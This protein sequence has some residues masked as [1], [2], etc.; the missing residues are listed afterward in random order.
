[1]P[2]SDEDTQGYWASSEIR[3]DVCGAFNKTSMKKC[4][5]CGSELAERQVSINKE[6]VQPPPEPPRKKS[7][8]PM[9]AIVCAAV[10]LG[11]FAL[12][13]LASAVGLNFFKR[14]EKQASAELFSTE[15]SQRAASESTEQPSAWLLAEDPTDPPYYPQT[16]ADEAATPEAEESPPE[17]TEPAPAPPP[18]PPADWGE[19]FIIADS[20]TRELDKKDVLGLTPQ[21]L[22]IARNEIYAKRGRMFLDPLL[23][24]YFDSK[25]WYQSLTV[26]YAPSV[27][28]SSIALTPVELKNAELLLNM[29]KAFVTAKGDVFPDSLERELELKDV[30]LSKD[31]LKLGMEQLYQKSGATIY[32]AKSQLSDI[33]R[34]NADLIEWALSELD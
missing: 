15:I 12:G 34:H 6:T 17:E 19:D 33:A 18:S 7:G 30:V 24:L 3:C 8:S 32:G 9:I 28:D 11:V 25:E 14:S 20:S 21:Q 2:R 26:K 10:I 22:R 5:V 27:F 29:E 31:A 4:R 23:T 16:S 1:M 13:Y